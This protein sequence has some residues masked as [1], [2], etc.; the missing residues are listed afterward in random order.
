MSATSHAVR[1]RYSLGMD[2][3]DVRLIRC[4]NCLFLFSCV[5][6]IVA[7][8]TDCEGDDALASVVNTVA[9]VVFC[10]VS[11]CMSAQVNHEI[12]VRERDGSPENYR[13]QR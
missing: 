1:E 2:E 8:M 5:L 10:C 11:G 3:D 13:M 7:C 6:N 9:D 12:K 4:S